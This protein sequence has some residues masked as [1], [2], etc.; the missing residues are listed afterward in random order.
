MGD[1]IQR[2][3]ARALDVSCGFTSFFMIYLMQMILF[4]TSPEELMSASFGK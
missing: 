1:F 4:M 2:L 3:K